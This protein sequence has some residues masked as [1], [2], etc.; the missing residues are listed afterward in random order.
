MAEQDGTRLHVV[1]DVIT[2]ENVTDPET[3]RKAI[4]RFESHVR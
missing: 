3:V 4:E 2:E 1:D